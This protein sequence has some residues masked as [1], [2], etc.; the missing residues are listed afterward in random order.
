MLRLQGWS[1]PRVPNVCL[2]S[3][4]RVLGRVGRVRS[5]VPLAL[6]LEAAP[7]DE[8]F[9]SNAIAALAAHWTDQNGQNGGDAA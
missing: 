5:H 7:K 1:C 3:E 4:G 9:L 2:Q 8:G 6:S